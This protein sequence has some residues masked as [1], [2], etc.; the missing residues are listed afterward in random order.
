MSGER[1]IGVELQARR[2]F[3]GLTIEALA[4][5]LDVN[6]RTIRS[7]EAGRDPIPRRVP[8]EIAVIEAI[9]T[10][11]VGDLIAALAD[12]DQPAVTVWRSDAAWRSSDHVESGRFPARW[13]RHVAAR[14]RAGVPGTIIVV[15]GV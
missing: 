5:L 2:E 1:M 8:G 9:T 14:A 15:D 11:A 3:L 4:G 13:W 7:W 10:A 12:A 6:P